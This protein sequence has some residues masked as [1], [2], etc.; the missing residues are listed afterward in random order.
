MIEMNEG[1]RQANETIRRQA[2]RDERV[3]LG[4][5]LDRIIELLERIAG[6][7]TKRGADL[8]RVGVI[9]PMCQQEGHY[10]DEC[11]DL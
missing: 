1:A 8:F 11:P 9:C 4:K 5:K 6:S 7:L 2:E 10:G 3:A